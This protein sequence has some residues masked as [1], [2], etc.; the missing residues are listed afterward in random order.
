[1]LSELQTSLQRRYQLRD[2]VMA[3]NATGHL[4]STSDEN[5]E[6]EPKR[7]KIDSNLL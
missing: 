5:K 1:M 7:T 3:S 6:N 2:D 4:P